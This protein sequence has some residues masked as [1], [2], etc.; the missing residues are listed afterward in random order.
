MSPSPPQRGP[1]GTGVPSAARVPDVPP[2]NRPLVYLRVFFC[3]P[4]RSDYCSN[5]DSREREQRGPTSAR[6]RPHHATLC[7]AYNACRAHSLQQLGQTYPMGGGCYGA[8]VHRRRPFLIF[9]PGLLP[10]A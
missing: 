7:Q 1:L 10:G 9:S 5:H 4:P 6:C 2:A 8:R 3:A